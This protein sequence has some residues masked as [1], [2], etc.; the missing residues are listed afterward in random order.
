MA[1]RNKVPR[2]AKA[3]PKAAPKPPLN[4]PGALEGAPKPP[5]KKAVKYPPV[6]PDSLAARIRLARKAFGEMQ[7]VLAV[8]CDVSRNA[9]S[10]WE[11]NQAKPTHANVDRIAKHY[12]VPVEWLV[13]G[14]GEVNLPKLTRGQP[15]L[16]RADRQKVIQAMHTTARIEELTIDGSRHPSRYWEVPLPYVQQ[17]WGVPRPETAVY[18]CSPTAY[19]GYPESAV[20][21]ID[22]ARR[23]VTMAAL[24][25]YDCPRL[26]LM[27][28]RSKIV[29]GQIELNGCCDTEIKHKLIIG[30]VVTATIKLNVGTVAYN[31]QVSE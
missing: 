27:L 24:W 2:P 6:P 20:F 22:T 13:Y 23:D 15:P 11:K 30:R 9:V 4:E 21:L 29:S 14:R 7:S 1:K 31:S 16:D 5:R 17:M 28:V 3:A 10:L 25:L 8:A 18:F 26:G 12:G 19:E